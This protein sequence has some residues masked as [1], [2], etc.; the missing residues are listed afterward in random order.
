MIKLF[1][2]IAIIGGAY[3]YY[4]SDSAWTL[5]ERNKSIRTGLFGKKAVLIKELKTMPG[6]ADVKIIHDKKKGGIILKVKTIALDQSKI[7]Q[8]KAALVKAKPRIV[9]AIKEKNDPNHRAFKKAI[10]R[11]IWITYKY[12]LNT[13]KFIASYTLRRKDFI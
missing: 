13:G 9:K 3:F 11:G 4:D 6:I 10:K 1:L 8:V 2:L 5:E 7:N 12:Y